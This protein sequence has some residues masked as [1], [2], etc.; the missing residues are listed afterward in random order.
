MKPQEL[1]AQRV[2]ERAALERE[3]GNN[4]DEQKKLS[5][6]EEAV[7]RESMMDQTMGSEAGS[8]GPEPFEPDLRKSP[9]GPD[10]KTVAF[11]SLD[12]RRNRRDERLRKKAELED[13]IARMIMDSSMKVELAMEHDR[14]GK[15]TIY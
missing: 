10:R 7:V 15:Q 5:V 3:E 9:V 14:N 13:K 6:V 8:T 2:T 4:N 11:P 1:K 12:V